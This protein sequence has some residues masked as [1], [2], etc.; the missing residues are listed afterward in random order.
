M[1]RGRLASL[2]VL[3]IAVWAAEM[4]AL[5]I[6]VPEAGRT[7]SEVTATVLSVLAGVTSG[8]APLFPASADRAEEVLGDIGVT[9]DLGLYRWALIVPALVAGAAAAAAYLPHRRTSI[10]RRP[11]GR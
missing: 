10:R 8:L 9:A 5:G 3:S 4:I 6:L 11:P 2:L 7:L 1:V